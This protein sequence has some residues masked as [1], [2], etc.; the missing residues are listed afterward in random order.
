MATQNLGLCASGEATKGK[1][2]S[3]YRKDMATMCR[4]R[5]VLGQLKT[6]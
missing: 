5:A 1:E 6:N 3:S 2:A 4:V